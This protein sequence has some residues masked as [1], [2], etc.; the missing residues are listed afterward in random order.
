MDP[1]FSPPVESYIEVPEF[2]YAVTQKEE[3]FAQF[4]AVG[5]IPAEAV[6]RASIISQREAMQMEESTLYK[7]AARLV[8]S[9]GVQERIRHFHKLHKLSMS[10]TL[11]RMEQE[12][13]AIA[14][15]DFALLFHPVDGPMEEVRDYSREEPTAV[16]RKPRWLAGDP[17]KNP[18]DLPRHI[19]AAVKE[20]GWDKD[21]N[22]KAKFHSKSK[23][24]QMIGD[25]NGYFKEAYEAQATQVNITLGDGAG[26]PASRA[27]DITP[28]PIQELPECLL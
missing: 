2:E 1:E 18:H 17:I 5:T 6:I 15:A 19:R 20:W 9:K 10:T 24:Q 25:L 23:A 13:A 28:K 11:E 16:I 3:D 7:M 27:I 26:T 22:L 4:I 21:G 8:R 12:L 14:Y